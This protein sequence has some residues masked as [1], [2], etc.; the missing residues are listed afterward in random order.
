MPRRLWPEAPFTR[1]EP[2]P[3]A[4]EPLHRRF[5]IAAAL[6]GVLL[7]AVPSHAAVRLPTGFVND[8]LLTGLAEPN[9]MAFLPDGRLLFTEQRTGAVRLFINGHIAASDPVLVV[10]DLTS[11][12]YERG[13]QGVAVDPGWPAR[14]YL[15][16][17]YTRV[18]GFC[19]LVRYRASGDLAGPAGESLSL[20]DSL[21]VLDDIP[22]HNPLHNSGCLRFGPANYLY[23]SLGDDARRQAMVSYRVGDMVAPALPEGEALRGVMAEFAAA[24]QEPRAPLTDGRSGL[25]V[26]ALL[27]AATESLYSGGSFVPVYL[28]EIAR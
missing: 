17:Y 5:H 4:G 8:I 19:R 12:D 16:L 20:G 25:R 15:Y 11:L 14:P 26:L 23:V 22:D 21:L 2:R 18:G 24:I 27:E 9:S 10:P 7:C 6:A 28:E 1:T 3:G 13:L